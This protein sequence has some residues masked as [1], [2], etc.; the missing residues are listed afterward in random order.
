MKDKSFINYKPFIFTED[1]DKLV[2]FYTDCLG[3]KIVRKLEYELDYGYTLEIHKGGP[4]VWLAKHS[5]IH[6]KSKEPVRRMLNLYVDSVKKWFEKVKV[7]PGVEI[8][9]V[10][11]SM[12]EI[13]PGEKRY[14]CTILDPDGNSLQF[15]GGL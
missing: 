9:A 7:Y 6:G 4:Q 8:I 15:M 12:G 2:K 14:A 3:W 10:P 11:F 1:P 13:V 5:E